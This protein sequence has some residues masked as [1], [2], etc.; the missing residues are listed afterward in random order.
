MSGSKTPIEANLR[1]AC[2]IKLGKI[3]S[4]LP[5]DTVSMLCRKAKFE[6][7]W[8]NELSVTCALQSLAE[9]LSDDSL[10]DF[11]SG[12]PGIFNLK[13]PK[14]IGVVMAGN[15]PAVGFHDA[16][17]VLLS[18]NILQAKLSKSDTCL[19][20][21][22]L[23]Q[24]QEI[25]P[26]FKGYIHVCERMSGMDA[27]ICTGSDNS[28]RYFESYF[29]KYPHVIRKNRTSLALLDGNESADDLNKLGK[30]IFTYFGLGCRNVSKVYIPHEYD[31]TKLIDTFEPYSWVINEHKYANN[32]TYNRAIFLM[33]LDI[34]LDNN[35]LLI[36]ESENLHSPISVLFYERYT[37]VDRVIKYVE[38]ESSKIQCVVSK[39][40][41]V[42]GWV[43]FGRTQSPGITDFADGVDTLKFILEL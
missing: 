31:I 28:A 38:T 8:F 6:N 1:I 24:I 22:L 33:N 42:K 9:M 16:L 17:C 21:F 3:L 12:Y 32:Y 11:V 30:D 41:I 43:P 13:A 39:S 34:F 14:N 29:G 26:S 19:M 15:I 40:P 25:E 35:F 5:P 27:V 23:N 36:K 37:D 18:G 2:F 20:D 7:A 10:T 4:T